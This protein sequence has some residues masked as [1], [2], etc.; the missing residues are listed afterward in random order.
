MQVVIGTFGRSNGGTVHVLWIGLAHDWHA[1]CTPVRT[2][3]LQMQE[4]A[5]SAGWCLGQEDQ[6]SWTTHT[7]DGD[8]EVPS[9]G[10]TPRPACW[11]H[12]SLML[13]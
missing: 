13:G 10:V 9:S 6:G 2:A 5:R 11:Q 7:A 1:P 12:A 3:M 8:V 4:S